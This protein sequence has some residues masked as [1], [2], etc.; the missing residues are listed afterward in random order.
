MLFKGSS[1]AIFSDHG[2]YIVESCSSISRIWHAIFNAC[3]QFCITSSI[4][5]PNGCTIR[6]VYV[7]LMELYFATHVLSFHFVLDRVWNTI[8]SLFSC[9]R[10]SDSQSSGLQRGQITY[11]LLSAHKYQNHGCWFRLSLL[12]HL[13]RKSCVSSHSIPYPTFWE[14]FGMQQEQSRRK[15]RPPYPQLTSCGSSTACT[16]GRTSEDIAL[17]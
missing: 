10:T 12:G 6:W 9:S 16:D 15:A 14:E 13:Y 4:W 2:W 5:C 17:P 1:V 7:F 11:K 3:D 8:L